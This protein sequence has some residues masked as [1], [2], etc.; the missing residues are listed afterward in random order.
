MLFAVKT[1]EVA[2]PEAFVTAVLIPPANVPLA[3][4]TGAAKVTVTPG[5]GLLPLSRTVARSG[6]AKL[7]P[8]GADCGVPVV[9]VTE[10]TGPL[11]LVRLKVAWP[12]ALGV[13][14]VTA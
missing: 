7:V 9:T 6:K 1:A 13:V 5:T 8:I 14:A 2:T 3:P 11:V 4:A 12:A 10:L